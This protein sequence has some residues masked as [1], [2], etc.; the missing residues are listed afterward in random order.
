MKLKRCF[1][2]LFC[3][4]IFAGMNAQC[5]FCRTYEDFH[6][7]RW[8]KLDTIIIEQH[9][10]TRQLWWGGNDFTLTCGDKTLDKVLQKEAFV[11]M[12]NDTMYVNCRN[13]RYEKTRFGGGFTKA[14]RIGDQSILFVNRMIGRDAMTR[15]LSNAY[16]FGT[17]G[18]ILTARQLMKHQVC[19]VISWGADEKGKIAIRM[20]DDTLICQMLE[21]HYDLIQEYKSEKA[22]GKRILASHVLPILIKAGLIKD[23][24]I[25]EE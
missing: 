5:R 19:Y 16:F 1:T 15:Q 12:H 9:S 7:D 17:V 21:K 20:I 11:V 4:L 13:L 10:K 14:M 25:D 22:P 2:L 8:E 3:L 6:N 23:V 18:S 24:S